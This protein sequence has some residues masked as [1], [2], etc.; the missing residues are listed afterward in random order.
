M[1]ACRLIVGKD[2]NV[3]HVY[4]ARFPMGR[5]RQEPMFDEPNRGLVGLFTN[6]CTS[7]S[8]STMTTPPWIIE[9]STHVQVHPA[10]QLTYPSLTLSDYWKIKGYIYMALLNE[11]PS[12][13]CSE[14]FRLSV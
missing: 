3:V 4:A 12:C 10:F 2:T 14:V 13:H 9:K 1:R 5:L 6:G 7:A 11:G 8:P